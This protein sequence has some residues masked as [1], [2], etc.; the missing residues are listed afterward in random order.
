MRMG[1]RMIDVDEMSFKM[2]I[3]FSIGITFET[4]FDLKVIET[5]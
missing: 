5:I 3:Y 4:K 1:M 2:G